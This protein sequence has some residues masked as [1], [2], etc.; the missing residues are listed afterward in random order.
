MKRL[1]F[2]I[3]DENHDVTGYERCYTTSLPS[4]CQRR[5]SSQA[6]STSWPQPWSRGQASAYNW[7]NTPSEMCDFHSQSQGMCWYIRMALETLAA[8]IRGMMIR[9]L[10]ER[11]YWTFWTLYSV[12]NLPVNYKL[13]INRHARRSD[14]NNHVLTANE[15]RLA[16]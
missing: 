6:I 4:T 16:A 10:R 11:E 8:Q 15:A 13:I 5:N 12:W 1:N 9:L 3:L 7:R 2:D 14:P